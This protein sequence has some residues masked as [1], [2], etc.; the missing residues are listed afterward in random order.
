MQFRFSVVP[1]SKRRDTYRIGLF[2]VSSLC[3]WIYELLCLAILPK[4][5]NKM[6]YNMNDRDGQ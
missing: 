1:F 2:L 5:N 6:K 4:K 3:D